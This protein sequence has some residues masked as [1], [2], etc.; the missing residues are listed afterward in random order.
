VLFSIPDKTS[1]VGL[2]LQQFMAEG[3]E[4]C[5]K[6]CSLS[7]EEFAFKIFK[8]LRRIFAAFRI[9][10]FMNY[11]IDNPLR[12][13]ASSVIQMTMFTYTHFTTPYAVTCQHGTSLAFVIAHWVPHTRSF[14][15]I[16][17]P[18]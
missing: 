1:L 17:H 7:G 9:S 3:S 6:V 18:S 8:D 12:M 10:K 2:S 14:P 4:P 11:L 16:S 13:S 15:A 5:G